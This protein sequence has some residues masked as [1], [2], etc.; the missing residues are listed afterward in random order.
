MS[1]SLLLKDKN[2]KNF[3]N[4][5][6][7]RINLARVKASRSVNKELIFLYW[8]IGEAIIKKQLKHN[9]GDSIVESLAK[10]LQKT[11]PNT[12]G[13]SARNLWDMKRL[14]ET[15]SDDKILRQVVAELSFIK[16]KKLNSKFLRQAVAEIPWGNNLLIL[17]KSKKLEEK[18]FYVFASA[19][20]GWSRKVLLNQIHANSYQRLIKEK[21][22]NNFIKALPVSLAE[23]VEESLK[24]SYNLEFLGIS[25]QIKE[26]ELENS[27]IT[28]LRD[29][30]LELGYGFSFIG[31]QY[32]LS[33]NNKD[34]YVDLLF[35]HRF[36]KAL[37]AI[38]LKIGEFEPEHAGKM[39]FYLNLLNKKEKASD[40]NPS[41]GLI[42]CAE[43]D[44]LIVEYSLITK[45]NPIGVAEYTYT[46]KL[47]GKL[48][49]KLPSGSD[50]KE[51]LAEIRSK[52]F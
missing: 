45:S 1:Q 46:K 14:V 48:K 37:V 50:F 6:K 49:G 44:D 47:P 12:A 8:D 2:Y 42:L 52:S 31:Q 34:Y 29:F 35:Y 10:D 32:K 33:L 27:L 11:F 40:D 22:L 23:Q 36:L 15:Y 43:K 19:K 26:R 20:F 24:S 25:K 16:M 28:H 51:A 9:W 39:D 18:I 21:K 7:Q 13:F 38:D 3:V 5:I 30:I 17:R 41:I 4:E